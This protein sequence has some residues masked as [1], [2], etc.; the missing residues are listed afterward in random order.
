VRK[1]TLWDMVK[2]KSESFGALAR[3]L[4]TLEMLYH[5]NIS[6][7]E[8]TYENIAKVMNVPLVKI[9]YSAAKFP[10][11]ACAAFARGL[12]KYREHLVN[13]GLRQSLKSFDRLTKM[14]EHPPVSMSD[15]ADQVLDVDTRI[16]DELEDVELWQVASEHMKY[17]AADPLKLAGKFGPT[18][19]DAEEAGKCLAYDRGTACVFHLMRIMECGLR[20]LGLSLN[21]PALD[22]KTNPTWEKILGRCD[23]ELQKPLNERADEWKLDEAFYSSATANLRAVKDAWRNPTLHVERDYAPE[24][25]QDVWNAVGAFMRHLAKKLDAPS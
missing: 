19:R 2:F 16:H 25:A 22:P 24:D 13:A 9:D 10:E 4:H 14:L 8:M 21:D 5:G 20:A 23:K 18:Y 7:M 11:D 6:G 3:L 1:E 17:L 12:V 15:L